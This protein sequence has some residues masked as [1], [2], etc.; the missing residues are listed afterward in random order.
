M[1]GYERALQTLFT[2][3]CSVFVRQSARRGDGVSVFTETCILAALPCR[4]SYDT[5]PAAKQN[6]RTAHTTG[7]AVLFFPAGTQIPAGSSFEIER[8]GRIIRLKASGLAK[9]YPGHV[10][11]T[12]KPAETEA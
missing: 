12:A 4:I 6:N 11:I 1:Y 3:R 10:E 8:D 7:G 9:Y 2:D 5:Y